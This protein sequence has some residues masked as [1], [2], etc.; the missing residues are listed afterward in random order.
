[1]LAVGK[2][3]SLGA[4]LPLPLRLQDL[5]KKISVILQQFE[6]GEDDVLICESPTT[7]KDPR[8]AL[9]VEQVRV[10]F[11]SLARSRG[12]LVPGRVNPRTVQYEIMGLRG[13]QLARNIVKETGVFV[14]QSLYADALQNLGFAA[15]IAHLRQHQD[16]VDALLI[17]R[18][19]LIRLEAATRSGMPVEE[20]FKEMP[21]RSRRL[22]LR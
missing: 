19:G 21:Q 12:M 4:S 22:T 10:T 6:L 16:I 3:K 8:A 2:V 13:K 14:V 5:H 11:E 1:M 20:M 9:K 7:M 18:M 17:G 15:S